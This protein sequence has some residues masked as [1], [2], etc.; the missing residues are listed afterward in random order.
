MLFQIDTSKFDICIRFEYN[1]AMSKYSR[2]QLR[3]VRFSK[4]EAKLVDQYLEKNSVFESFSSLA[5]VASLQFIKNENEIKLNPTLK[6]GKQRPWFLWDYD[7][8]KEQVIEAIRTPGLNP[9]KKFLIERILIEGRYDE[10]F[11]Y[12]TLEDL[13]KYFPRLTLNPDVQKNWEYALK[14]WSCNEKK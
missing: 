8:T 4:E 9:T 13:N 7:L 6:D 5:R 11:E 3:T 1:I 12:L 10:V 14:R 2:N